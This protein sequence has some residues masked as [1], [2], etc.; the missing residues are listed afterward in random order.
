MAPIQF[1]KFAL[2]G[3]L[4]IATSGVTTQSADAGLFGRCHDC[5]CQPMP[6]AKTL[7]VVDPCTGCKYQ[8][9]VKVPPCC[10]DEQPCVSWRRG[11]FGR[12]VLSYKWK[13]C[14]HCVDV[15]ITKFGRT[16]VRG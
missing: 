4:A 9:C 14:G 7:C 16:I 6:V 5:V 10:C 1:T 8:V 11:V 13:C 2:L 15:V 12:K 3:V